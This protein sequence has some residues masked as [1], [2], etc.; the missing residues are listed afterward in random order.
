MEF[1]VV[2][3]TFLLV[4][5]YMNTGYG[6]D[7]IIVKLG[8][9]SIAAF[10]LYPSL[11]RIINSFQRFNFGLPVVE[12]LKT[13]IHSNKKFFNEN[14]NRKIEN[15]KKLDF[16]KLEISETF[17]KYPQN[18]KWI[19]NNLNFTLSKND[20]VGISGITGSGKTTLIDIITGL[21]LPQKGN[22]ILNGIKQ[23][24]LQKFWAHNIAYVPQNI[25]L[26]NETI[27]NNITFGDERNDVGQSR[28][29]NA[30]KNSQLENFIS[31]LPMGIKTSV[32][33]RGLKISGGEKQR[34]GI[35]RA[36]YSNK[37]ILI[38]DEATN[39]LDKET[40]D[41]ILKFLKDQTNFKTIIIISH[42]GNTLKY[43]NRLYEFKEGILE[44]YVK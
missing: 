37:Q 15:V 36:L 44:N 19:I 21:L 11:F 1:A 12:D 2:A 35:A 9:F 7:I 41:K 33:E 25:A 8:I 24:G 40:E 13:E 23:N 30:L 6:F 32:G 31:S 43:C 38:F 4:I 29:Q 16:N 5:L 20:I 22:F 18:S 14:I 3:A 42:E 28:L 26:I 34:I 10:R 27:E 17:F 39:A